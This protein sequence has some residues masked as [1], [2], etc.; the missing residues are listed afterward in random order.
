MI[1][2]KIKH[3][4]IEE[5]INANYLTVTAKYETCSSLY[6]MFRTRASKYS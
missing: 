1:T 5:N 4:W 2:N 3:E 6:G